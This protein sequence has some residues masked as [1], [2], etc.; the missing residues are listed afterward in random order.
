MATQQNTC[1]AALLA[2]KA[3]FHIQLGCIQNE[4]NEIRVFVNSNH[5]SG[6]NF[7]CLSQLQGQES[8]IKQNITALES[9]I[10]A[11]L[12]NR[13]IFMSNVSIYLFYITSYI[14]FLIYLL[15]ISAEAVQ[16]HARRR[17]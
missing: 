7:V 6:H 1:L 5:T 16:H 3:N 17:G 14:T 12:D 9:Q 8:Y 2:Q 4:I 11:I 13:S 15:V 10:K